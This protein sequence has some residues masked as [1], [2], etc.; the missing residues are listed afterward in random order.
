[1]NSQWIKVLIRKR[2]LNEKE[3]SK[4]QS[5]I[6]DCPGDGVIIVKENKTKLDLS[7]YQEQHVYTFDSVFG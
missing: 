5:D 7:K 3:T 6:V 2:P 1:M 4:G